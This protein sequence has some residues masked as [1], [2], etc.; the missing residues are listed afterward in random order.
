[1]PVDSSSPS[2]K[3][4]V[5]DLK[6]T[7]VCNKTHSIPTSRPLPNHLTIIVPPKLLLM[8]EIMQAHSEYTGLDWKHA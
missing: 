5:I 8:T 4:F 7:S 1:M 6:L 3:A 2:L